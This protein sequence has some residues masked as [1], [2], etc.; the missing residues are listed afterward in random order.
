MAHAR[1]RALSVVERLRLLLAVLEAVEFAHSRGVVH[2]DLKPSNI[3]VGSDGRPRLLDFGISKLIDPDGDGDGDSVVTRTELR[4]FTPAYASPEQFRG[5]PATAASDVY[6]L[7]VVLYELLAGVR[8]H[9]ASVDSRAELERAVLEREPEPPSTVARRLQSAAAAAATAAR[10]TADAALITRP[11]GGRSSRDLDAICLK[12][13]RKEPAERYPTARAFAADLESYLDGRPVAA[14][15]GG[16]RYRLARFVQRSRGR[17]ATTTAILVAV[18]ATLFAASVLWRASRS[19]P[20]DPPPRP[21]PFSASDTATVD[22]LERDFDRAPASV[23]AGAALALALD[24]ERRTREAALILT[25]LRQI[26]GTEED[27]LVDYVEATLAFSRQEPQRALLLF[28]RALERAVASGR[29]E[30]VAQIRAARGRLLSTLGRRDEAR[31]EMEAAR[32][33]F[34]AAGDQPSLARVLNDLA[35]EA[36]QSGDLE[37]AERMFTGALEADRAAS[38][39]NGGPIFLQNLAAVA[40]LRGRPDITAARSH[41]AVAIF[42]RLGDPV[43]V[44]WALGLLADAQRDLGRPVEARTTLEEAIAMLRRPDSK[45][46]LGEA[47]YVAAWA[48]LDAGQLGAVESIAAEV[49]AM[50]E[51]TARQSHLGYADLL[52]AQLASLRGEYEESHRRFVEARR[53]LAD[54]GDA[55]A[56]AELDLIHGEAE[57]L[58]GHGEEAATLATAARA[59]WGGHDGNAIVARADAL[60]ARLDIAAGRTAAARQRLQGLEVDVDSSPSVTLRLALLP[61]RAEL[62]A[63]EGKQTEAGRDLET[64]RALATSSE[65][66]VDALRFRLML[67]EV[68]RR[69]G[70]S[71]AA[72]AEAAVIAS[73]AERLGLGAV[74]AEARRAIED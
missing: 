20:S 43:K 60:L 65:R 30:L 24:R 46:E 32:A 23:E 55:D 69:D 52:R 3:L 22:A 70:R 51:A 71:S 21:F 4:A 37:G 31:R 40:R 49:D 63:A 38:P 1:S 56:V 74:A 34:V 45:Y 13:L 15:R 27:P 18:I 42:R 57:R 36:A 47:L 35:I 73:E 62:L 10:G 59:H 44:G 53:L 19:A 58:A 61:A 33:A 66:V 28:T 8:P 14:R 16:R 2:R 17:L 25:R 9:S 39:K 72:E 50:A 6:S 7:G 29:G 68:E 26:P 64:A 41:E 67:A 54:S 12:A 11:P 5:E 48:R